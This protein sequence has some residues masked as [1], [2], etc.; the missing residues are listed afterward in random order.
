VKIAV[1]MKQVPSSEARITIAADG[2]TIDRSDVEMVV[3]P[4]DEF[5]VEEALRIKDAQ[6]EGEVIV[7]AVGDQSAQTE[8]RKCLAMGADRGVIVQEAAYQGGDALGTARILADVIRGLEVDLVLCG[9]LSIDVEGDATGPAL[10]E[11]LDWPHVALVTQIEWPEPR[12]AR[13]VREIEGGK[14]IVSVGLPAVLTAEK[15][16]NEPRYA[17][18]KGIMAAKRKQID[19]V[20]PDVSADDVAAQAAGAE[21]IALEP[22]PERAAGKKFEGEVEEIVPQVVELLKNEAK[23]L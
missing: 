4:Y 14:E 13:V 11:F 1:C 17:S 2:K 5:A 23:V 12:K 22:P 16:L 8:M 3:N 18:L 6:G 10:A 20:T 7:V 9:K 19:V 15:G 21:I